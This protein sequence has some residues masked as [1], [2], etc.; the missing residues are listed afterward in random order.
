MTREELLKRFGREE[1][2][3]KN[4]RQD[5]V[6]RVSVG[7]TVVYFARPKGE[8]EFKIKSDDEDLRQAIEAQAEIWKEEYFDF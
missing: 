1:F 5:M 3:L 2:F 6:F 7:Q 8:D 4:K